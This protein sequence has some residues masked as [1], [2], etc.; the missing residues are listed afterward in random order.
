M[1]RL[2][3]CTASDFARMSGQ[4]LKQSIKAS[5]G[6]VLVAEVISAFTPLYPSV[7]NAELAASFGADMILLNFFDVFSPHVEGLTSAKPEE[8]VQDLKRLIGRPVG[9]NLEPVDPDA[10]QAEQLHS[11]PPGRLAS[12]KTFAA[13]KDLG[14]DF[15]CLTGN[16]K[17][18]V[19]NR[20]I[21]E[22]IQTARTVMGAEMLI[23]AGKMHGAGVEGEAGG[24]LVAKQTIIDF[25][26]AGA[27]IILLPSPGTIPGIT[28]D[29]AKAMVDTVH[30]H[31]ALALLATGTS[32]EGSDEATIRQIA[33]A[34]KMAGAD[35]YH[36]GDAG[37]N[38]IAIPENIMHYSITVRGKRHT[39]VRMASSVLR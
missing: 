35:L 21:R 14:F 26:E 32:Q 15:I 24:D 4:D 37:Y 39:Y 28:L 18:G 27:D 10:R 22:A 3:D 29:S 36:I 13:A 30:A 19:T 1:K 2:L 34:S 6:R 11:L 23:I 8:I 33:L 16:P 9:L 5:E 20:E 12:A 7:S 17:T 25:I 38:G 31:G